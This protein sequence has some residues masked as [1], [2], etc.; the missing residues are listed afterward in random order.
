[1]KN[2]KDLDEIETWLQPMDYS[3][4]WYAIAPYIE[5]HDLMLQPKDHCDREIK[6]GVVTEDVVLDVLKTM[7]RDELSIQLNLRWRAPTPWAQSVE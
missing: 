5:A 6:N 4:F 3:G 1:M 2:F 7:V